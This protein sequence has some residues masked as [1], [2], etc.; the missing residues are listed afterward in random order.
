MGTS[1]TYLSESEAK[2]IILL[3]K[4]GSGKSSLGNTILGENVFVTDDGPNSGTKRCQSKTKTVNGRKITL[5]DTP[6]LFDSECTEEELMPE[7]LSC[8]TECTPG[9]HAFLIVLKV[10]KFS[11]QEQAIITK[12]C[13]YFSEEALQYA[14]VVFTHG[15]QLPK[16]T[17]IET[18]IRQSKRLSELVRKCGNRC[19]VVDNMYWN[20]DVPDPYRNNE[21]QV[22][23]L[24]KTIDKMMMSNNWGFYTNKAFNV[25]EKHIEKEEAIIKENDDSMSKEEIRIEAK[26][27]VSSRWLTCLVGM[28]TGALL[29]P[30]SVLKLWSG[31]SSQHGFVYFYKVLLMHFETLITVFMKGVQKFRSG[32]GLAASGEVVLTTAGVGLGL[33]AAPGGIT[34]GL[35]GGQAS[36]GAESVQEAYERAI[37]A[38]TATVQKSGCL[39]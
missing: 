15:D 22:E 29:G 36:E 34:G 4:T 7:V 39:N 35:I 37:K 1:Y 24:L 5:I 26:K 23:S 9:P 12:I 3:G 25:M 31:S 2:R 21:V 6:G 10:E 32:L 33:A 13:Q 27:R 11:E 38:V 19:H 16:G 30:F 20:T 28:G 8:I 17:D 18:F 14:T